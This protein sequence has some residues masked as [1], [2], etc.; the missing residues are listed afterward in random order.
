VRCS[1][2]KVLGGATKA[3]PATRTKNRVP[4]E[5]V[6]IVAVRPCA[7]L[8][9]LRSNRGSRPTPTAANGPLTVS[10]SGCAVPLEPAPERAK[11]SDSCPL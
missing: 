1:S 2:A 10:A 11:D 9:R 5:I 3:T 4:V 8:E 6:P 7:E